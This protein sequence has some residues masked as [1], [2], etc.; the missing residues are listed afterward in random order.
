MECRTGVLDDSFA[1]F[2]ARQLSLTSL[3][4]LMGAYGEELEYIVLSNLIDVKP[5][6][7]HPYTYHP[8]LY[9]H[10]VG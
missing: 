8:V 10:L 4:T 9:L 3:L 6:S 5:K 7:I 1:L 2:M